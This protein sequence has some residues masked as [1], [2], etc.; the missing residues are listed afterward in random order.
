MT[1]TSRLARSG[2]TIDGLK[3]FMRHTFTSKMVIRPENWHE[4]IAVA[5]FPIDTKVV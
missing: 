3:M 2:Q 1:T 5:L 4:G